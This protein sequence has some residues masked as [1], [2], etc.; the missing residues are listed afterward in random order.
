MK[1][2]ELVFIPLAGAGHLVPEVEFAKQLLE[3][4]DGRFSVT[5][6]LMDSIFTGN[7]VTH[8]LYKPLAES[9]T[10]IRFINL[11][12]PVDFSPSIDAHKSI[13][14]YMVEFIDSHKT[15]VKE[16]IV[17][18]VISSSNSAT[19]AGLVLDMSYASMIDVGNELGVPSYLFF[20]STAAFLGLMLYL[21]TRHDEV[22]RG[23]EE[24]DGELMI[25]SYVN[26]VPS[27]GLPE[28]LLNKYGGYA[29][30]MNLG[31]KFRET[32]GIIVN[33]FQELESHAVKSLL[34]DFDH[35]P[36]IYTVGPVIDVKG[37]QSDETEK[38]DEIMK[39]LDDQPDSS[40]VFLCFGS[41][42]SFGE[43]QV[44][45]IGF[46]LEQSGVRF[47]WSLRKPP[48]N[49]KFEGPSDY[50]SDNLQEILPN[51][52][53]ERTK[54]KGL[55]CGRAP[56]KEVLAHKSVGGFVSH[57]G[58]NSILES[59]W[60][61][62]PIVT[63]PMYAEQQLNAFQMVKDL[64]LALELRVDYRIT[65]GEVVSGDEIARAIKCVME[66]DNEVRKK[67]KE[68]SEKSRLAVMEEGSSF[69]AFGRFID[70]VLGNMP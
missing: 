26:P 70:D 3:R 4:D 21:P 6:L 44:K 7:F 42:G 9:N 59:L 31:R 49:G 14:K 20:P 38:A 46:G 1:K 50:K 39:W 69:A 45:E 52:F 23:F 15:C 34:N 24:F 25:P 41:G 55:V 18:H 36:P 47:L 65:D 30:L 10:P 16:A 40:V 43:E 12:P 63:W 48:P 58:W 17:K 67:V 33:T 37:R 32:K 60:F 62:I 35:M 51:G 28:V 19:L 29:T 56:Q 11:P 8:T 2:A 5:V 54:E 53:L 27:S 22:G 61:G 57:C 13:E 68:M 64:G 66:S